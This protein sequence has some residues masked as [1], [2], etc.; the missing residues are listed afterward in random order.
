MVTNVL[1]ERR[2]LEEKVP[3]SWRPLD[4]PAAF[5]ID[6]RKFSLRYQVELY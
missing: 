1:T 6:L 2:I 5:R 3:N 4:L